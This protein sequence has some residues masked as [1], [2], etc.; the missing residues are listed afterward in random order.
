MRKDEIGRRDVPVQRCQEVA[1]T[2]GVSIP[3]AFRA[4]DVPWMQRRRWHVAN[5]IWSVVMDGMK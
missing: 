5:E 3:G 4:G 2:S 1:Q